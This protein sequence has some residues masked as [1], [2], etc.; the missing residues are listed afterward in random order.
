MIRSALAA[1][2]LLMAVACSQPAPE[3][4]PVAP[5]AETGCDHAVTQTIAFTAPDAADTV[6]ARAL[7]P[8]CRNVFVLVTVRRADGKPLWVWATEKPW[9]R[10]ADSA[11]DP[12][13]ANGVQTFL[14]D[15]VKVRID[16][17]AQLPEW[18]QRTT[19]FADSLGAF[20]ATPFQ[21]DQYLDIRARAAPRLCLA[22]GIAH[23]QCIYYDAQAGDAVKVL[24]SG[25]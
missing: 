23:S 1:A 15:L 22:T 25:E 18:P 21:R 5:L 7:G 14:N 13:G 16:T 11:S 20:L 12:T 24:E 4:A 17:T 8:D 10:L 6:E 3:T 19:A 2:T 9:L